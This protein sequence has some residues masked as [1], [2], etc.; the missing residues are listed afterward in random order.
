MASG[1]RDSVLGTVGTPADLHGQGWLGRFPAATESDYRAWV[2]AQ[3]L[4]LIK[5]LA[6]ISFVFWAALPLAWSAVPGSPAVRNLSVISSLSLAVIV[7]GVVLLNRRPEQ[8]VLL[9]L[10]GLLA[11][12][13]GSMYLMTTDIGTRAGPGA[14]V[15]AA[16]FMSLLCALVQL[17]FRTTVF[18]LLVFNGS[19]AVVLLRA[20]LGRD[21][22]APVAVYVVWLVLT[23]GMVSGMALVAERRSRAKFVD[24]RIIA[25]QRDL[26]RRYVPPTVVERIERG[27]AVSVGTPQR[28]RVTIL[29]SDVVGFTDLADRI[30]PE[31]LTQVMN[32]YLGALAQI[33]DRHLGTLNEFAGDGVLALFGAPTECPPEDQVASA[34]AAAQDIQATLTDL[35]PSWLKLGI[36]HPIRTRIGI[37]T[38]VISVGSF[39]SEG[40]ATYTGIGLQTNIAGRIQAQ[41]EPGGILLSHSSW[42]LVKEQIPC[43]PHGDITVKGVHYP[44]QVFTPAS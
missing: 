27:D 19:A 10:L 35:N 25:R 33:I 39:G 21:S 30:D 32:E 7:V 20:A 11:T 22:T 17:P 4:P 26:I 16:A 13:G 23:A 29:S 44:I 3:V 5:G 31:T 24:E 12:G 41:C 18:A 2:A 9:A 8:A 28:R 6:W 43:E 40:R 1:D 38:G 42:Q 34:V 36:D 15:L 14:V 37:N